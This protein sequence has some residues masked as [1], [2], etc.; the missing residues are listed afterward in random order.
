MT[1]SRAVPTDD[2][3]RL[4]LSGTE[5]AFY[6]FDMSALYR[7][8]S[9]RISDRAYDGL[10]PSDRT[11]LERVDTPDAWIQQI[12][13]ERRLGQRRNGVVVGHRRHVP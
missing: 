5:R 1:S 2:G 13:I 4:I 8:L 9:A 12:L 7:G 10:T 3:W 6:T 11:W